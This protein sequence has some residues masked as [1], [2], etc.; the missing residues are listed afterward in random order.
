[1]FFQQLK[2]ELWKL[3]A[4]KRTYIGFAM[5]LLAQA[6]I[7][8]LLRFSGPAHRGLMHSVERSGLDPGKYVSMLTVATF[9]VLLLAYSLLPL[10][11]ALV[12]GDLVSKE[13]EDGTLR[14]ILA[15]P[16]SRVRLLALKWLAGVVFSVLLVAMLAAG[17]LL[18]CGACFPVTGG[19]FAQLPEQAPSLLNYSDGLPRFLVAHVFMIAKAATIMSLAFMFSCCNIKP[20]AAAISA[21]SLIMIDRI[22]MEIPFF[23]ELKPYFLAHYLNCW[24]LLLVDPISWWQIGQAVSLLAGLS[25]TFLIL[26]ISIFQVR[27]IKS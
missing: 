26:G 25:V 11:V 6:L 27:D 16:V 13:A 12:G 8:G 17:S 9:M 15:R 23:H 24:Q 14:M 10:F 3:F 7:V 1:M 2:N 19:L 4:K 21:L 18:F 5:L 20:A 22:L